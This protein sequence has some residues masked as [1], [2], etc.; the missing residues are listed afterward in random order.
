[1]SVCYSP[2]KS[3]RITRAH[4]LE[5]RLFAPPHSCRMMPKG[6]TDF[7][8]GIESCFLTELS[9]T[10]AFGRRDLE[11][12]IVESLAIA[13]FASLPWT[14]LYRFQFSRD[15]PFDKKWVAKVEGLCA[16]LL[17]MCMAAVARDLLNIS[18]FYS[19][20]PAIL[21]NVWVFCEFE[22]PYIRSRK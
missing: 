7:H 8:K 6:A 20:V 13:F 1:M 18:N 5:S 11:M 14:M 12:F 9:S 2:S 4:E 22:M 21:L 16:L 19:L 3:Q 15:R 17:S 10:Q